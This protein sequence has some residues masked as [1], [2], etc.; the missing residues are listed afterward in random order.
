LPTCSLQSART[1]TAKP[2]KFITAMGGW[3]PAQFAE[4]RLPTLAE[5]DAVAPNNP[6][7]VFFAF[8][9][10]AM[11]E[12][13]DKGGNARHRPL[14]RPAAAENAR[15]IRVTR[16]RS[17]IRRMAVQV[18]EA[19][20]ELVRWL[21]MA[22]C[23]LVGIVATLVGYGLGVGAAL[24]LGIQCVIW[25]RDGQ[26]PEA[27]VRL[28]WDSLELPTAPLPW[29]G[30]EKIRTWILGLPLVGAMVPLAILAAATGLLL[31]ELAETYEHKPT[32]Q[33]RP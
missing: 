9:G 14:H 21:K 28:V 4:N 26:W 19:M 23:R 25:L 18:G 12:R 24:I 16:P 8:T 15:K 22:A 20:G 29:L 6:V 7:L 27:Q 17:D 31:M 2:G 5:L 3:N 32:H 1:K 30:I 11:L 10:C 13:N 33:R